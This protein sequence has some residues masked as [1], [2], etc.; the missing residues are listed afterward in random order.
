MIIASAHK[1]TSYYCYKRNAHNN[2][3]QFE[4]FF[5]NRVRQIDRQIYRW[6]DGLMDG[7]IRREG[8]KDI[9]YG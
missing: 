6:I 7:W 3:G 4:V 5:S 1:I 8:V 9:M 2:Y